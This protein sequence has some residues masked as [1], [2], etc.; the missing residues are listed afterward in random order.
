MFRY[1]TPLLILQIFC[2]YHVYKNKR[3]Y[4]WIIVILIFPLIGCALYLYKEFYNKKNI[5]HLSEGIKSTLNTEYTISKLEK[6]LAFSDTVE[7]K[8]KVA[9]EY[10]DRGLYEEA[11]QLY[12]SCLKGVFANDQDLLKKLT[13]TAFLKED[14]QAVITFGECIKK[15]RNF[16]KSEEKIALAWAYYHCNDKI[17]SRKLF[18]EMNTQFTNY[19]HR[20]EFVKFLIKIENL[21][22]AKDLA[23]EIIEEIQSMDLTEKRAKKEILREAKNLIQNTT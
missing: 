12:S 4:W 11:F 17:T 22:N 2:I 6:K 5:E 16:N 7:N 23:Q 10:V 13:K 18:H 3:A 1:F 19:T 14:F 9:D 8:I 20:I 15:D 21:N